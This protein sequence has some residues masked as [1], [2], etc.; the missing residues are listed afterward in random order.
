MPEPAHQAADLDE[1]IRAHG[2]A[3]ERVAWG[4]VDNAPDRE[5]LMQEILV[6][7]WRAL[8]RFRGEASLRTFVLRVAHNRAISFALRR[9][10]FEDLP[11]ERLDPDPA[12][13]ADERLID[14][15]Q[16]DRLFHAIRTLPEAQRQAVMLYLEGLSQREIAELQETSDNNVA[17]RL[18]RAR[19]ALRTLLVE[20][21]R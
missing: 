15:Q 3:L 17:V 21:E 4:Y 18:T 20:E 11:E 8:P 13:L 2:D 1:V 16:R 14:E 5:D 10:R 12:P 6:A 7:L 19:K 9:R